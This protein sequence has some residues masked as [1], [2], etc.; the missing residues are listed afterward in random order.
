MVNATSAQ[1]PLVPSHFPVNR[2]FYVP[3]R[4]HEI[5]PDEFLEIAYNDALA[6][7]RANAINALCN[8]RKAVAGRV[9]EL[10]Y[11]SGLA[12]IAKDEQWPFPRRLEALEG[13][14][15]ST[16]AGLN[17]TV[18]KP[19]NDLEH[20]YKFLLTPLLLRQLLDLAAR[21]VFSTN[22]YLELGVIR[23]AEFSP[24]KSRPQKGSI[25]RPRKESTI[26][27]F[28]YDL[29][30]VDYYLGNGVHLSKTFRELGAGVLA[31][32]Y[33]PLVQAAIATPETRIS[34]AS[35]GALAQLMR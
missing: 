35:E 19:R 24:Y 11:A 34:L 29:N 10:L 9:D 17:A 2:I 15:Y 16:P 26:L 31:G 23:V 25:R 14:G 27:I 28:D 20:E 1:A 13:I 18:V 22:R 32:I 21:Y 12:R 4:I 7:T 33:R 5:S 8:A 30:L 6:A 3:R